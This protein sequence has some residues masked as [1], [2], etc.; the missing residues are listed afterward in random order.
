MSHQNRDDM[1]LYIH[2]GFVDNSNLIEELQNKFQFSSLFISHDLRTIN[3]L[4]SR[5]AIMYL[6]KIIEIG[7][8]EELYKNPKHPYTKTLLSSIPKLDVRKKS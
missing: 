6:G 7:M 5:V 3:Y 8:V 4:S 1:D 2:Y